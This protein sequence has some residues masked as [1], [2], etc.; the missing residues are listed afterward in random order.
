MKLFLEKF[1]LTNQNCHFKKKCGTETNLNMQNSMVVFTFSNFDQKY[2]FYFSLGQEIEIVSLSWKS[3]LRLTRILFLFAT[4][5]FCPKFHLAFWCYLVNSPSNLL[6]NTWSQWLFLF[7][8]HSFILFGK[9]SSN[10]AIHFF[11]VTVMY[12]WIMYVNLARKNYVKVF[13]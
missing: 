7:Y 2:T 9:H 12:T 10:T 5:K 6:V 1:G 8:F 4:C 3:V 11:G 13:S